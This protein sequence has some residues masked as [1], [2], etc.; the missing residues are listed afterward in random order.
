MRGK[1]EDIMPDEEFGDWRA[2]LLSAANRLEA[3]GVKLEVA[4]L[5]DGSDVDWDALDLGPAIERLDD[6]HESA[7][8]DDRLAINREIALLS[9]LEEDYEGAVEALDVNDEE[10]PGDP[11][12]LRALGHVLIVLDDLDEAFEVYE[13]LEEAAGG[14]EVLAAIANIRLGAIHEQFSEYKEMERRMRKGLRL[15]E[16]TRRVRDQAIALGALGRHQVRKGK[17]AKAEPYLRRSL[18]I[19]ETLGDLWGLY[20]AYIDMGDLETL[21]GDDR[22]ALE[23]YH[24]GLELHERRGDPASLAEACMRLGDFHIRREAWDEAEHYYRKAKT[25]LGDEADDAFLSRWETC[26]GVLDLHRGRYDASEE[27]LRRSLDLARGSSDKALVAD[28]LASLGDL[29]HR[30]EEFDRT[31]EYWEEA[32][33]IYRE[34]EMDEDAEAI[35]E[36]LAGLPEE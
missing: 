8:G 10:R 27:H 20:D 14:N 33:E 34:L 12:T 13:D 3:V 17:A 35:E 25:A 30:R 1:L 16:K 7:E 23:W 18:E 21:R 32:V 2:T 5:P 31:R 9:Y 29:Y 15:A 28:A 4:T 19:E 24:K 22:A 26:L 36:D 11:A 6:L